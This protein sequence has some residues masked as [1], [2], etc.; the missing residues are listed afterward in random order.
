MGVILWLK[1]AEIWENYLVLKDLKITSKFC[2]FKISS[3]FM[4][5]IFRPGDVEI[6]P[7]FRF[8]ENFKLEIL[9]IH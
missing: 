4:G 9:K 8:F 1:D 2:N 7:L 5:V 6:C 3:R